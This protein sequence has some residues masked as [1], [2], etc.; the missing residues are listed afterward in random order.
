MTAA[1]HVFT[2]P[3]RPLTQGEVP[4]ACGAAACYFFVWPGV[5]AWA[6]AGAWCPACAP[7]EF[8]PGR[9]AQ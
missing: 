5:G 2:P 8:T 4:C 1:P 7:P 9:K 3:S 6:P